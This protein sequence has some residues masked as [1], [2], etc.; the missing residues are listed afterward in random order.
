MA[1]VIVFDVRVMSMPLMLRMASS[2]PWVCTRLAESRP[3]SAWVP[4]LPS[5]VTATLMSPTEPLVLD[6]STSL[7]VK[8]S[9]MMVAVTPALASLIA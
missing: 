4:P 2:A 5:S 8:P 7:L 9:L 1:S 3:A 6:L